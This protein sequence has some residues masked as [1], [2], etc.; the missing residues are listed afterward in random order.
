MSQNPYS[1]PQSISP[2]ATQIG[3]TRE[4]LRRVATFQRF[5]LYALLAN[6]LGNIAAFFVPAG[7]LFLQLAF[8]T[9][10]LMIVALTMVSIFTLANE[11]YNVGVGILCAILVIIPCIG[12]ITLLVVNQKATSV[13]QANGVKVGLMGAKPSSI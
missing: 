13:L 1:P 2:N 6:I 10:L 7:N 5:V 12:L 9:V 4:Y 3:P 8:L 11:V